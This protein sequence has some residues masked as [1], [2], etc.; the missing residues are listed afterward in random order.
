M[1]TVDIVQKP[2]YTELCGGTILNRYF[3]TF[4]RTYW[5]LLYVLHQCRGTILNRY[6]MHLLVY[7]LGTV[8]TTSM[9][10]YI[11]KTIKQVLNHLL[12]YLLGNVCTTSM[13]GYNIKKVLF[14]PSCVLIEYCMYYINAG[15]QY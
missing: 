15:V 14:P 7:L 13:Q 6:F 10:G 9:Q 11:I 5:V 3:P 12:A 8:C 2:G 1:L 4:L